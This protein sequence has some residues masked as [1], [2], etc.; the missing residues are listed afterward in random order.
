M[1]EVTPFEFRDDSLGLGKTGSPADD[2]R[3]IVITNHAHGPTTQRF[4][5]EVAVIAAEVEDSL[6]GKIF[7]KHPVRRRRPVLAVGAQAVGQFDTLIGELPTRQKRF[8]ALLWPGNVV[9]DT[10]PAPTLGNRARLLHFGLRQL[11]TS[12]S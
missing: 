9:R 6:S 4:K 12:V 8:D 2:H 10:V 3:A 11:S 7:R 1:I 5:T